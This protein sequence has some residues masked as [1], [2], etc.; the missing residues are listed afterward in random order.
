MLDWQVL[1]NEMICSFIFVSVILMMKLKEKEIRVTDDGVSGALGIVLTLL[2]MIQTGGKFGACYNPAVAITLTTNAA[3]YLGNRTGYLSHYCTFYVIGPLLGASLAGLF[4]LMHKSV[5]PEAAEDEAE[6]RRQ[7]AK[8]FD[9]DTSERFLTDERSHRKRS[10]SDS[11]EERRSSSD[12]N[13]R[14]DSHHRGRRIVAETVHH[15]VEN[16]SGRDS[17]KSSGH[18]GHGNSRNAID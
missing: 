17:D 9:N 10:D 2:G 7:H 11:D 3:A 15:V 12:S 16:H 1:G 4:H 18:K 5:L 14:S 8:E 13:S 6:E